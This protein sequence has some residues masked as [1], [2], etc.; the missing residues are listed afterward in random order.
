MPWGSARLPLGS[1]IKVS[2]LKL[3]SL[4][5]SPLRLRH[6]KCFSFV[7]GRCSLT[8]GS[9]PS[10]GFSPRGS[11]AVVDTPRTCHPEMNYS[12][13]S[14]VPNGPRS[15]QPCPTKE[16]SPH[17]VAECHFKLHFGEIISVPNLIQIRPSALEF[18]YASGQIGLTSHICVYFMHF[19]LR[20]RAQINKES[21]EE[22][23][24]NLRFKYLK[25][26]TIIHSHF[27]YLMF[28]LCLLFVLSQ[29]FPI[30]FQSLTPSSW[31]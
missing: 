13:S 28:Y 15:Y 18:N 31:L 2:L 21:W 11:V 25:P 8:W 23:V 16:A 26:E 6:P 24:I 3:R 19:V 1:P 20:T 14:G 17:L 7:F 5:S 12:G 10:T 4:L 9:A 29:I 22:C 30:Q 27:C